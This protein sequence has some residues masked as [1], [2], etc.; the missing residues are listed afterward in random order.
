M[1]TVLQF[2]FRN[3]LHLATLAA[4]GAATWAI[5]FGVPIIWQCLLTVFLLT[6]SIYQYNRLT[7]VAE[8]L[9]NQPEN[10]R[11]A[12]RQSF[13]ITY[14]LFYAAT[15]VS[16]VL[17]A[18]FG[19]QTFLITFLL[20]AIGFLYNQKCFPEAL[21]QAVGGAKRLKDLY[22]IKNLVPPIDWATAMIVLPLAFANQ[23][24]SLRAWVCWVYLFTCA[25]FIEVM[26][27]IRDRHGDMLSGIKTIANTLS[28]CSTKVFLVVSSSLSGLGLFLATYFGVLPQVSYF[29]LSNNVAVMVI[30]S[31]YRDD[32]PNAARWL[33]DMTILLAMLLFASFGTIALLTRA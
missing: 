5:Y 23:P 7:D 9:H 6:L 1:R 4:L 27:D 26:W 33:S 2:I 30:A 19:W 24:I 28:L 31:S 17:A 29:L 8:D 20:A 12:Q 3:K 15:L 32:A 10:L 21:S 22:I 18:Q 14:C 16:L 11:A 13:F 25:F